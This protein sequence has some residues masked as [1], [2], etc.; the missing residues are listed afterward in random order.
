VSN[1]TLVA[2][3]EFTG[4]D[5]TDII[6]WHDATMVLDKITKI[7]KENPNGFDSPIA[8]V[9]IIKTL[10]EYKHEKT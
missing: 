4:G 5:A 3:V 7:I 2:L 1:E 6:E 8:N 10:L 9:N